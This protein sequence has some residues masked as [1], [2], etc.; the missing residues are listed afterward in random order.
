MEES[1]K[2]FERFLR[3]EHLY[4]DDELFWEDDRNCYSTYS[5]HIAWKAWQASRAAIDMDINKLQLENEEIECVHLC[6]DD[7]G[8]P[9]KESE[10]VLSLWGRV[11]RYAV[12]LK[13]KGE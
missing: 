8:I 5:V 4:S 1:R 11:L 6:L 9:R 7:A 3:E 2:Q 13:I 10:E 12:G